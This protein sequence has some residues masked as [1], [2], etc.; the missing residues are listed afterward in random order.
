MGESLLD[1]ELEF[2]AGGGTVP[3]QQ[4]KQATCLYCGEIIWSV[5]PS[6]FPFCNQDHHDAHFHKGKYAAGTVSDKPAASVPIPE[7]PPD[8][9]AL[10][11]IRNR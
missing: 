8:P 7:S 1:E 10:H 5:D 3:P 6:V 2:V 11:I 9:S 4:L